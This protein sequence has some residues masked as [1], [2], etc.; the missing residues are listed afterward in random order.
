M[1]KDSITLDL[2]TT[3]TQTATIREHLVVPHR[4]GW[5]IKARWGANEK[6]LRSQ[7]EATRI[8]HTTDAAIRLLKDAGASAATVD[9]R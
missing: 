2:L 9:I 1:A 5:C 8:F 3:L 6:V 7:R 4:D